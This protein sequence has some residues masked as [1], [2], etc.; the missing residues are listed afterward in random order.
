MV[1][2]N[3]LVIRSN[4]KISDGTASQKKLRG[5]QQIVKNIMNDECLRRIEKVQ[6]A[7]SGEV[8]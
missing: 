2:S 1:Y 8:S 7:Y 3:K 6:E 5:Q 4:S